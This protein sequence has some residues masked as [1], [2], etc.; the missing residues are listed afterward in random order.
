MK[1]IETPY[2]TIEY[3]NFNCFLNELLDAVKYISYLD[4]K[5][6]ESKLPDKTLR[7]YFSFYD[8]AYSDDL[9]DFDL[10]PND[11]KK[12]NLRTLFKNYLFLFRIKKDSNKFSYSFFKDLYEKLY[13]NIEF[14]NK[15]DLINQ[16]EFIYNTIHFENENQIIGSLNN[17]IDFMN[18]DSINIHYLVKCAIIYSQFV[19][20]Q[21]FKYGNEK[22]GRIIIP[23]YLYKTDVL[24]L[25][26]FGMSEVFS[27]DKRNFYK[28]IKSINYDNLNDWIKY[29]LEK[30][31]EQAKKYINEINYFEKTYNNTMKTIL[32]KYNSDIT[33]SL[34]NV[35]F[36]KISFTSQELAE[37]MN[38]SNTQANRYLKFLVDS[39]ILRTDK[40]Q[41]YKKY[42][43]KEVD[44]VFKELN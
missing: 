19:K 21:P 18:D 17:L 41:R 29:F 25:P 38:T 27:E 6:R 44:D 3:L 42:R 40:K 33:N 22:I 13:K 32:E 12:E 11:N 24:S 43:L 36:G 34:M 16:Y 20:I 31:I 28:R 23:M 10:H 7:L 2:K 35:I 9:N 5:I 37:S 8:N 15:N 14:L 26:L 30:C 4:C 1:Q 39:N